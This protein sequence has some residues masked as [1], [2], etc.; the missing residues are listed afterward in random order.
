M[1]R[2]VL[3]VMAGLLAITVYANATISNV[4]IADDG[5]GAIHCTAPWQETDPES[6]T[7]TGNQIWAPGHMVGTITTSDP[8]DPNLT[9]HNYIDNDSGFAW[10]GYTVNIYLP[11]TFTVS[12]IIAYDPNDWSEV[13]SLEPT[14]GT[15]T[16]DGN[17]RTAYKAT[18][19]YT[20]GEPVPPDTGS[21]EF[22]YRISF[23]GAT[24]YD[25]CQEMIPTP[26][27]ATLSLLALGGLALLR[28]KRKA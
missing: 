16:I 20:A 25:F 6:L 15:W 14:Y 24:S 1:C 7:I 17:S 18:I 9:I 4:D 13:L 10:T 21:F 28:R 27:P 8:N 2:N 26:E 5:D 11:V 3:V 12:N 23:K 19:D 22:G